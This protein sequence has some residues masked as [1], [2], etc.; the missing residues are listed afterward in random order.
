MQL[1]S[2]RGSVTHTHM[3]VYGPT[4]NLTLGSVY[5]TLMEHEMRHAWLT[6]YKK[7][8]KWTLYEMNKNT[9]MWTIPAYCVLTNKLS[10]HYHTKRGNPV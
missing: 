2:D 8:G 5:I 3:H 4:R 7:Q 6:N 1:S 10:K 9:G